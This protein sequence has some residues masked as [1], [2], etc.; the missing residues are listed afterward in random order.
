MA[1]QYSFYYNWYKTKKQKIA[2][3]NK[4]WKKEYLFDLLEN[5]LIPYK[6]IDENDPEDIAMWNDCQKLKTKKAVLEKYID[7]IW[8]FVWEEYSYA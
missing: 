6:N 5:Y 2:H 4:Y 7:K 1:R 8:E 3:V